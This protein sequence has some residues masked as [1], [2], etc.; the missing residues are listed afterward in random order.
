MYS[1]KGNTYAETGSIL[2]GNRAIGL[3]LANSYAPFTERPLDLT[4]LSVTE[5]EIAFDIFH[6]SNPGIRTF[7]DAKKYII[8]KRYSN[9][10]QLA[11]MLNRDDDELSYQKMQEWREWAS[12][13]ARMIMDKINESHETDK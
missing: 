5:T 9:D 8:Q 6:W 12:T 10:D 2:Q 13:V 7:G 4:N 3:W 11:I 1:Y